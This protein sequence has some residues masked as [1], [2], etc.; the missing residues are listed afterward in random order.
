MKIGVKFYRPTR[1]EVGEF[2]GL[3]DFV[4]IMSMRGEDFSHLKGL[5]M[6]WV[7][8]NE[9][10]LFDV[11]P[12]NPEKLKDSLESVRNSI[13]IADMLGS[14]RIIVHLGYRESESCDI[15]NAIKILKGVGDN[16]IMVENMPLEWK[17]GV[18]FFGARLEE[19]KRVIKETGSGFC[20]DTG[21]CAATAQ[22]FGVNYLDY[23]KEFMKLKPRHFHFHDNGKD[24]YKDYHL[25]LG[26]GNLDLKAMFNLLPKNPWI[27]L[28]TPSDVQGRKG[29]IE[30]LRSLG[31]A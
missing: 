17:D 10:I 30:F 6:E 22:S 7:I 20:F 4:E 19:V 26:K 1:K 8:H 29:D 3:V 24:C 31:R 15:K 11:N 5:G 12:S 18:T 27:T 13:R 21:H 23:M 25:H 2:K 16:R 9:H 28:E 14:E